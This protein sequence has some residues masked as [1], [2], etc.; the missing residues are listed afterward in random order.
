MLLVLVGLP[1]V[2]IVYDP[3]P[4]VAKREIA[5]L[6]KSAVEATGWLDEDAALIDPKTPPVFDPQ[7][8]PDLQVR[9]ASF[10]A[11]S[12]A[13]TQPNATGDDQIAAELEPHLRFLRGLGVSEYALRPWGA[14]GRLFRFSCAVPAG[15]MTRE[16]DAVAATPGEAV[17][18]VVGEV[19]SWQNAR[20][21]H[22]LRR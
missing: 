21:E 3:L 16:F 2:W 22:M 10:A 17:R 18:E 13:S 8:P 15:L 6:A 14:E 9:P 5:R 4:D 7:S 20:G 19:S 11:A 1:A 12:P